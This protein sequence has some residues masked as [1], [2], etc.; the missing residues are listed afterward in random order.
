MSAMTRS[1]GEQGAAMPALTLTPSDVTAQCHSDG[2]VVSDAEKYSPR[3]C[4]LI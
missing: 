3:E 1:A 4:Y 2:K